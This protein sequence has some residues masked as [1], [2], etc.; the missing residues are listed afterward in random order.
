MYPE[1]CIV[2]KKSRENQQEQK[3]PIPAGIEKIAGNKQQ[4]VL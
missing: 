4:D 1:S 3:S 2:I